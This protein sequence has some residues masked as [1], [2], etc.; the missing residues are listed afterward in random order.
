MSSLSTLMRKYKRRYNT[1]ADKIL[2]QLETLEKGANKL[3]AQG[4]QSVRAAIN[5]Y[6]DYDDGEEIEEWTEWKHSTLSLYV[7]GED[8]KVKRITEWLR[9]TGLDRV[10]D[11]ASAMSTIALP[12]ED[13]SDMESLFALKIL[14][15]VEC[16]PH[17]SEIIK[18]IR[19]AHTKCYQI[20]ERKVDKLTRRLLKSIAEDALFDPPV[21][22]AEAEAEAEAE[23]EPASKKRP[24]EAQEGDTEDSDEEDDEE[25][26]NH[27]DKKP[28]M[29]E[30]QS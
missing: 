10:I 30:E 9:R 26:V 13:I 3:S 7:L 22:A 16:T 8:T 17:C 27:T 12:S 6:S 14:S 1:Q 29:A 15:V 18:Q 2:E 28:R 19:R 4:K 21:A 23:E 20:D 24:L 5:Q 25:E 11:M